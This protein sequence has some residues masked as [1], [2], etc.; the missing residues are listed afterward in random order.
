MDKYKDII[1]KQI[2]LPS[3]PVVIQKL[4]QCMTES[5]V[6]SHELAHII[7]TDQSFTAR[8][9]RLVNSPFYGFAGKIVSV[10][11]A[12]AMLGL[13]TIHQLLL[14]TSLLNTIKVENKALDL[15]QF[16]LHSFGVGVV[17]KHLLSKRD[18]EMQNQ[19]FLGGILHDIGRLIFVRLDPALFIK[20]YSADTTVVD[21]QTEKEFFGIDHEKLG[22]ILARKWNFP[23]GISLAI[24]YHHSPQNIDK[25]KLLVS[26]VNIANILCHAL[27][28]GYSGNYYVADFSKEAWETLGLSMTELETILRRSLVEIEKSSNMLSELSR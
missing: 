19:G 18:K 28:I 23:E 7:E 11:E 12:I 16:W 10:D 24:A 9:L 22:E 14:A 5:D 13:N 20:F 4:Q 1:N 27:A 2:N 8:I 6:G 3:P 26:A 17:A 25:H 21:L 15:N